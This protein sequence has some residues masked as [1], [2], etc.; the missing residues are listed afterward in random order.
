MMR[1]IPTSVAGSAML[2][3]EASL[4]ASGPKADCELLPSDPLP[5]AVLG[6]SAFPVIGNAAFPVLGTSGVTLVGTVVLGATALC[7]LAMAEWAVSP[8]DFEVEV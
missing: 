3:L 6:N 2:E 8:V 7:V 4:A 1:R 5:G